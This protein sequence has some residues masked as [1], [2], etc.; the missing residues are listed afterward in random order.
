MAISNIV[1]TISGEEVSLDES[2]GFADFSEAFGGTTAVDEVYTYPEGAE[3][4]GGFANMN[5]DLYP[6]DFPYGGEVVFTAAVGAG[7]SA[8][9]RFRFEN[10][11][12]SDADP[13]RVEPSYNT[14]AVSVGT[15]VATEYRIEIPEQG[16]NTF[17]SLIMY[18]DT[19]EVAVTITGIE[20]VKKV[21]RQ[22]RMCR[23]LE[24]PISLKRLAER[25]R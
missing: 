22:R 9:V 18:L 12:Y 8:D 13:S 23:C 1:I 17:E 19:R 20:I 21:H 10:L 11:P 14:E 2:L 7:E 5:T 16:E 3:S 24:Q 25:P 6:M 15:D 4:W